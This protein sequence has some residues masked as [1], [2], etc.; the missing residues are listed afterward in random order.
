MS[1]F[2]SA[3]QLARALAKGKKSRYIWNIFWIITLL[4]IL[5]CIFLFVYQILCDYV[6]YETKQ[7]YVRCED[8]YL[9][10]DVDSFEIVENDR[11]DININALIKTVDVGSEINLT[12]NHFSGEL[13]EIKKED[14]TVYKVALTSSVDIIAFVL[15]FVPMLAFVVFM[16]VVTNIKNPG[17]RIKNIQNQ[18]LS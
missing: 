18:F 6:C 7:I 10:T 16:L 1:S 14:K 17:R 2:A 3:G 5:Y 4:L 9:I 12:I 8:G 15:L 11:Q 13:L